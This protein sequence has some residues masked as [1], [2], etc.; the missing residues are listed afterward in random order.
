M[1]KAPV[2]PRRSQPIDPDGNPDTSFEVKIPADVAWTFQTLDK[3]GMV[4]NMAQTWH[5][6]RPGERRND[7]GGCHAH[8]QKPTDFSPTAAAKDDYVPWDLTGDK[9][10]LLTTKANDLSGKKWDTADETGVRFVDHVTSVEYLR[11]IKPIFERSCVACHTKK[12]ENPPGKLVLDADDELINGMPGTYHRLALDVRGQFGIKPLAEDWGGYTQVTR[13]IR[14]MQSRRSLL[15]WKIFGE[16]LDGWKNEDHPTETV[17]GDANTIVFN[18]EPLPND[19]RN[20]EISDINYTGSIM[21]PPKAVAAGKVKALS[22]EDKRTLVRWID[23]GCPLDLAYDPA[24]PEKRGSGWMLDEGR[25]TLALTEPRAG[26]SSAPLTRMLIGMHDYYAGLDADSFTV[27]AE[28]EF[29]GVAPGENLASRFKPRGD[30]VWELRLARPIAALSQGV[31]NVAVKDR[32]GNQT[33]IERVFQIGD[34][35]TD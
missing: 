31:I 27:T 12:A 10:P 6:V 9:R 23:L 8:S 19:R 18:G 24:M 22:D 35:T 30:G 25:P 29:D 4:L 20:I 33:R 26:R 3:R 13:Y 34:T 15:A 17:P 32:E 5:Q 1:R 28:F 21:P 14:K 11:D 2:T 7:C 16:R